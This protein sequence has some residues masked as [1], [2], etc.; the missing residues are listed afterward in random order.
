MSLLTLTASDLLDAFA[1]PAPTPGGGSASALSGAL[2]TALLEM[3]TGLARTRTGADAE[4]VTLD[5][6]RTRLAPLRARLAALVD[7]DAAAFEAVMAAYRLPKASEA[8]RVRRAEAVEAATRQ[9]I[10]VP[11][12]VMD[13]AREALAL[14]GEVAGCGN[15]NAASD[16]RVGI[17]LLVAACAGAHENVTINL[18]SLPEAERGTWRQRADEIRAACEALAGEARSRL[19]G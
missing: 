19:S 3:V 5:A 1:S 12:A 2:G 10:E 6:A 9:A 7:A 15:R 4:R 13:A 8:D 18:G 17:G 11:L 16:V 14:A